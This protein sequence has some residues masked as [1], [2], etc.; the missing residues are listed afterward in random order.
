MLYVFFDKVG[1]LY[2]YVHNENSTTK[3][4]PP[5]IHSIA[6]GHVVLRQ[7]EEASAQCTTTTCVYVC[8]C[9]RELRVRP[10]TKQM[11]SGGGGFNV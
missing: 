2:V 1:L 4:D 11:Q 7:Q 10:R 9:S 6:P 8:V 3:T 5:S